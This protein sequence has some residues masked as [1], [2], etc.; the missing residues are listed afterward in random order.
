MADSYVNKTGLQYFYNKLKNIFASKSALEALDDKVDTIID[1]GG[2]PNTIETISV[3][4]TGVTPDVNKNVNITVPTKVS[5]L[6]NDGDGSAGSKFATEAYVTTNGGKIDKIQVNGSDQTITNKTVN[7]SVPTKTSDLTNDGNGT[8]N[9]ATEA[10]VNQNGGK[11]DKI[12]VNGTD[13]TITSKTV[14]ISV[15]TKVSDLTNDSK[16]QTDTQVA[17]AISAAVASAY[18]YK[19]SVATVADLPASGN[20]AGD[21]YD[22]QSTGVNYAWTGTAWDA[23]GSYVDTSLYWAKSELVAVTTAEID[24]IT[25][26]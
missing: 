20:T 15:P 19:G 22:V 26:A 7:L 17:S 18:K 11:I 24:T 1:E 4:N 21:V 5:D 13:Q 25:A 6:T 9:F 8:S 3:N 2:E 10:Y 14:N 16:F 12:Q 23:L